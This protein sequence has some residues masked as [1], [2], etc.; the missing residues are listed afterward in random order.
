MT[1]QGHQNVTLK[2][3]GMEFKGSGWAVMSITCLIQAFY[4]GYLQSN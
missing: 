2:T 4:Q 1:L 3:A